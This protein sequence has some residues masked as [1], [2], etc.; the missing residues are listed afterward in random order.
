MNEGSWVGLDVHAR[1]V[2]AGVLDG[3]SG[4][5]RSLLLPPGYEATVG[6]LQSLPG[7]VRVAY[8]AGPTGYGLAVTHST[9]RSPGSPRSRRSL[10]SWVGSAAYAAP[11][12]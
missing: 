3:G 12:R 9:G 4:E 5:L 10:R 6:W 1:S 2:V 7:P 8:E 11:R